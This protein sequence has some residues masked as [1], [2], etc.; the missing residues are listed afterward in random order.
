[1]EPLY[2]NL[3]FDM[4]EEITNTFVLVSKFKEL[5]EKADPAIDKN[6]I[7]RILLTATA[8]ERGH[9]LKV[10]RN[11]VTVIENTAAGENAFI[12]AMSQPPQIEEK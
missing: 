1:M 11:T 9:L 3:I 5:L 6:E 4:T 7:R 10:I 8:L 12:E 2:P